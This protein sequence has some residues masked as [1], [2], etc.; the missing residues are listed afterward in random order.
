MEKVHILENMGVEFS[1][2]NVIWRDGLATMILE[3]V[4]VM[5]SKMQ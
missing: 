2:T 3:K 1:I 4:L 5:T